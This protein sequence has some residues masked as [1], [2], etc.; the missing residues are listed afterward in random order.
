MQFYKKNKTQINL[1]VTALVL[2]FVALH[3]AG[4][5]Q[6]PTFGAYRSVYRITNP[7]GTSGGTGFRL[8]TGYI[9]TN[10]HVCALAQ[11]G[12]IYTRS[13]QG[14]TAISTIINTDK[15]RDLCLLS[16]QP[17]AY[18]LNLAPSPVT[19]FQPIYIVGHPY[20][21]DSRWEKGIY[22]SNM[23][24]TFGDAAPETGPC[25]DGSAPINLLFGSFCA[26]S[27]LVSGTNA[28]TFPGN[29]GSPVLNEEGLV[30]GVL[31]SGNSNTNNGAYV[32]Y[33]SLR[34]F[35]K[36]NRQRVF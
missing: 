33:E 2:A 9:I 32:P 10:D 21:E 23:I 8:K 26:R 24:A 19:H 14:E 22:I 12:K 16:P 27:M 17:N 20:L 18:S 5:N 25:P 1:V 28:R 34:S 3:V 15:D 13:A 4:K 35:L 6:D 7:E 29:S 30:V 11:A 36:E 31:N